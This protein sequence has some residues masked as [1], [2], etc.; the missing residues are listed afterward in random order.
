MRGRFYFLVLLGCFYPGLVQAAGQGAQPVAQHAKAVEALRPWIEKEVREKKLPAL[1]IALVDDQKIVWSAGFGFQDLERKIPASASTVYRVGSVSKLFTDIAIMQLVEKGD[2]DLDAPLG[3]Y[4]PDFKPVNPFD[5]QAITL[6]HL[7]THRSGLIRE[8]PAGNYF[9][10]DF[11]SLEKTVLSLNG[12]DL[13]YPPGKRTKYSNAAIAVVGRV[14][15]KTA[16]RKFEEVVQQQV[17]SPLG[18]NSSAF[19]PT[20]G[21]K[22]NLAEALMWSWQGREFPAP[23]FEL[24]MVPAGALYAPVTDLASF[25]SCL[26]REGKLGNAE[27]LKKETLLAM[28]KPQFVPKGTQEGFGLG[29]FASKL[30]GHVKLGHGGAMY[31]FATDFS[32]LP[33]KKLAAIVVASRDVANGTATRI[34]N[35]ALRMLLAS[36][37][38]K[39]L[40]I[41]MNTDGLTVAEARGLAGLYRHQDRWFT[42]EEL[43]GRAWILPGRGG[44]R[45]E[46]RKEGKNL[47]CDDPV[48]FGPLL[49]NDGGKLKFEGQ[50]YEKAVQEKPPAPCPERWHGLIGEYGWDHNILYILERQGKLQALIEWVFLYPLEEVSPDVFAFPDFGLYHGEKLVFQRHASGK[51]KQVEAAKVVFKRIKLDGEDGKT[52][53]LAPRKPVEQLREAA[54]RA[55]PPLEKGPFKP[56]ELAD[57]EKVNPSFRFDIRYAGK[58]NFLSTPFYTS[59]RAFLQ[60]PAADALN[61]VQEQL[62][63]Q[64]FGLLIFDAYRPWHVTKMFWE[65]AEEKYH[66]FVA[67]PEKG[68]RHNRGCAVDLTLYDLKT[69][70]P[71]EM[72]SGYDEFS[73][74]AYPLYPG[75]KQRQR[76]L[77]DLLRAA[78]ESQG[79]TVYEGEWWHFDFQGWKEYPILNQRFEDLTGF[80]GK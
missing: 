53:T 58:N 75:G 1:S 70:K 11:P 61:R 51:A 4:L 44:L 48:S 31:G 72:P 24:G 79:F 6:R 33:D 10:P 59:A 3:K 32:F 73:D 60:R 26:F 65:A 9:D 52:F 77:R 40:P 7:M 28:Y 29:F 8:P 35:E 74:R 45:M 76:H 49:E 50:V 37:E 18:M 22:K 67:D 5:A 14:L 17:L 23:T 71:V 39:P 30:D 2:L 63:S 54:L 25:A 68:S 62:K 16:G 57:L 56:V 80:D 15:E 27:L 12:I 69:G 55:K 21:V 41:L 42:I 43:N 19:F 66:G 34:A 38:G 78:M 46:L 20:P 64:G 13:V 36:Q 47:R